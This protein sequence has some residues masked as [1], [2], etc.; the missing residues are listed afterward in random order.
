MAKS[1]GFVAYPSDPP[2]ISETIREAVAAVNAVSRDLRYESWEE[3]DIAG[4]P[5]T[6]P[7]LTGIEEAQVIVADVTR[8]N[9]N[10]TYEI[11]YAIGAHKRVLLIRNKAIQRDSTLEIKTGVFDTLGYE[12]YD[13]SEGLA[14]ILQ[15][16]LDLSPLKVEP[17]AD[18]K[19]PVY[20]LETPIRTPEMTR[21][22][23][24]VKRARLFYRSYTPSEDSRLSAIDAIRHVSKSIGVL[25]PLLSPVF[26]DALVHNLRAAFVAGLAH[27]MSIET[28]ILQDGRNATPL[29]LRDAVETYSSLDEINQHIE[30]FAGFV[31]EKLQRRDFREITVGSV[32]QRVSLGD[33]MAENEFQT[34]ADYYV[35]TDEYNRAL[36]GEVNLVVGRKGTGKTALFFQ[37]RDR[38][39]RDR[40]NIVIDLKPEGYQL[41]KLKEH[42]LDYLSDGAKTHLIT[43]F[44]E[45][46]LLLEICRKVVDKHKSRH[47]YDPAMETKHRRLEELHAQGPPLGEGDFSE[48]LLVL[49]RSIIDSYANRYSGSQSLRLTADEVTNLL[50][51]TWIADLRTALADYLTHKQQVLVLFDNLDKG[52]SYMGIESGD[53]LILRCLIDAARKVQRQMRRADVQLTCIV[54]IRNDIYQLLMDSSPDFGKES[55]A[56]LDWSDPDLLREVLRKR[57]VQTFDEGISFADVWGLVCVSHYEGQETSQYLIER[58]LMRPRNLI[59]LVQ[60]CKGCAVNL[61][62]DRIDSD[63]IAK[64]LRSYSNDLLLEADRELKDVEPSA[65][66]LLYEFVGESPEV[67]EDGLRSLLGSRGISEERMPSVIDCLLY[68]GF[69]GLRIG[70]DEPR[71]I[72]EFGYDLKILNSLH[73]KNLDR[74]SFVLN[75]AFWPALGV[76]DK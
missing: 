66:D 11:G 67:S 21:I 43:S 64:G 7:I 59:K 45:Y 57:L 44:W 33:P 68:L 73:R 35:Q 46:L 20:L 71:Y 50:H 42:V 32:L 27:G 9:F 13:N 63:D 54:F 75:P 47:Q 48:R 19:T 16:T 41:I 40:Q 53:I 65:E 24:R 34:L 29:D 60:Y 8:L 49:S 36:R 69:L 76:Q 25:V 55:R 30:R 6:L 15:R 14:S 23:A 70:S 5:I 56:S 22:V 37:V 39:R 51:L 31:Y 28:L 72:H 26:A 18:I 3:K 1:S 61:D 52:W 2:E 12:L 38:V 10:V 74:S 62:H 58:S 17:E 4:K